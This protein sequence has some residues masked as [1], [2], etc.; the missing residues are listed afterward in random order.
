MTIVYA[1]IT[2][3]TD[4]KQWPAFKVALEIVEVKKGYLKVVTLTDIDPVGAK[5]WPSVLKDSVLPV[6]YF[7]PLKI[8]AGFEMTLNRF[9][10]EYLPGGSFIEGEYSKT[11]QDTLQIGSNNLYSGAVLNLKD[12]QLKTSNL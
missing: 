4:R 9:E 8:K 5:F 11:L 10:S 1:T 3:D 12:S 2:N 6:T 7:C